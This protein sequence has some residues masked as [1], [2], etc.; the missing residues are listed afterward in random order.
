MQKLMKNLTESEIESTHLRPVLK[1]ISKKLNCYKKQ[2]QIFFVFFLNKD[3]IKLTPTQDIF[4]KH[5]YLHATC[6]ITT[7]DR[8]EL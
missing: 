8:I 1:R 6:E 7:E 3:N 2:K 4:F 5:N